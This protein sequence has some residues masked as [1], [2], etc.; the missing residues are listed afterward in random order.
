MKTDVT[1]VGAGTYEPPRMTMVPIRTSG[2]LCLSAVNMRVEE[3]IMYLDFS[4]SGG[5]DYAGD[6]TDAYYDDWTGGSFW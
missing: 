1:A 6:K 4:R 2:M 5:D 3:E